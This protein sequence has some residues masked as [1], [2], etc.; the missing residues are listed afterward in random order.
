[1]IRQ[2]QPADAD[3]CCE[4]IH[5]CLALDSQISRT[6]YNVL[7]TRETP[8]AMWKRSTLFYL[9]V[10]EADSSVIGVAGLDMNE[11]RL[12]YVSP[13]NQNQG[14]G[15]ALLDHLEM[16]VPSSLFADIFVYST[17]SAARFYRGRGFRAAGEY[18]F[19]LSGEQLLTIFMR[20][21]LSP[22]L[23]H[24]RG[25]DRGAPSVK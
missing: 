3:A 6:L 25:I 13:E 12:L 23:V 11:V 14:I 4:L 17:P 20:K 21:P 7:R 5:S 22:G 10:C 1:M 2:F 24:R 8:Q 15:G 16:L 9:A 18:S 19:D